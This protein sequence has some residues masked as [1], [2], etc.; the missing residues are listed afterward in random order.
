MTSL[1]SSLWALAALLATTTSAFAF[2]SPPFPRVAGI[3]VGTPQNFNDPNYQAQ[4]AHYSV[5]V[6]G[7]YPGYNPGGQSMQSVAQGIKSHNPNALVFLYVNENELQS[8]SA[9]DTVRGKLDANRWWLYDG[10][11]NIVTS[12]FGWPSINNTHF[13]APDSDGL[14][15]V[16]WLTK[17]FYD[18]YYTPNSAIDGFFMDNVFATPTVDADWENSGTLLQKTNPAAGT[19]LRSGYV[20]YVNDIRGRMPATKFQIGNIR[21]WTSTRAENGNE[22]TFGG[23][24]PQQYQNLLNG[25]LLESFLGK[26]SS[27]ESFA[28]NGWQL[29]LTAYH[30]TMAAVLAPKLV[31]FGQ[32]GNPT[33]YQAIRYGLATCLMDDGYYSFSNLAD[34]NYANY[35]HFDE[36]DANLG[37]A[38][39]QP[40]TTPWQNGVYRRDFEN[41]IALVNPK[42]NG[43]RTVTL[44]PGFVRIAGTQDPT[45]NN[46]QSVTGPITLQD[47]DGIILLR[48]PVLGTT[49]IGSS[50]SSGLSADFKRASRFTLSQ[51]AT[52]TGLY[53][54][55]DGNGG[56]SGSQTVRMVVYS[57]SNGVPGSKLADSDPVTITS[58][59]AA[60]WVRFPLAQGPRLVAGNYWIAIHSAGTAGVVRDYGDPSTPDWY[61]NSD[62]FADGASNPFGTG[63]S[64]SVTL[65]VYATYSP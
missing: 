1:R 9:W 20:D 34:N 56:T 65:S 26:S 11:G 40:Q 45:T 33:D 27:W 50:P 24:V 16:H 37:A 14:N 8:S 58:G 44:E 6:L 53:A 51:S 12:S 23:D 38:A 13:T 41:G 2:D 4:L 49:S 30:K 54:Y 5:V 10:K 22:L 18:T 46:G 43:Q 7:M 19:D 29:T 17:Y 59:T 21:D 42:G 3:E 62:S 36:Y 55:L 52:L 48:S 28:T 47:R 32:W 35:Y 31:I 61:G 60:S 64:G 15:S 63:S 57:D 39:S 25:G